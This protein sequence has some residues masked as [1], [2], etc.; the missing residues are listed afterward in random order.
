MFFLK[1]HVYF[2]KQL[3]KCHV[4]Q[5]YIWFF[6]VIDVTHWP[7]HVFSAAKAPFLARFRVRRCGISELEQLA[8]N[9]SRTGIMQPA[10]GQSMGSE[11][12]QAAIF[13][14][15][16]FSSD[17][18]HAQLAVSYLLLFYLLWLPDVLVM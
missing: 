5:I 15:R 11:L 2:L 8:M 13:K 9:V 18:Q 3:F 10:Q 14:V 6:N 17:I 1:T 7:T 16:N 12:W 4:W